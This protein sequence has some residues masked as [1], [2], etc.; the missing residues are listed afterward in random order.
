MTPATGETHRS[1]IPN[2]AV[3]RL[4]RAPRRRPSRM[5]WQSKLLVRKPNETPV[6]RPAQA[7]VAER[8][9][10]VGA[11]EAARVGAVAQQRVAQFAGPHPPRLGQHGGLPHRGAVVGTPAVQERLVE[12]GYVTGAGD[13]AR[14]RRVRPRGDGPAQ[15]QHPVILNR[16]GGGVEAFEAECGVVFGAGALAAPPRSATAAS[17][18]AADPGV[19]RADQ[20]ARR[21]AH[22]RTRSEAGRRDARRSRLRARNCPTGT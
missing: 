1:T 20:A 16:A 9:R 18:S 5:S 12:Q 6:A 19:S 10:G 4:D 13:T 7:R 11:L 3:A 22:A 8:V 15:F 17:P 21:C 2:Q 14:G